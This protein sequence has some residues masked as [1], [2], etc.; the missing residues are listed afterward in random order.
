MTADPLTDVRISLGYRTNAGQRR[1]VLRLSTRS[2]VNYK[3]KA[4]PLGTL[5]AEGGWDHASLLG[6]LAHAMKHWQQQQWCETC[7]PS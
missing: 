7:K 1:A 3:A 5:A 6:D 2:T 4:R